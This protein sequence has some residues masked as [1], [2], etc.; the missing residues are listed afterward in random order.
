MVRNLAVAHILIN[1]DSG[2]EREIIDQLKTID[3]VKEARSI[4]GAYDIIIKI[5]RPTHERLRDMIAWKIS[6]I[7]HVRTT[8]TLLGIESQM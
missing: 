3:G 2:F 8:L 6:K 1:C 4:F 5:E 7:N